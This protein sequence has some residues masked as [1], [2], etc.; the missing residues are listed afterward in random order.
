[1]EHALDCPTLWTSIEAVLTC[2]ITRQIMREP[3][4]A[5][6]GV[7][8]DRPALVRWLRHHS[9]VS[10]ITRQPLSAEELYPNRGLA[11]LIRI[12]RNHALEE[13]EEEI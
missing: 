9:S 8:Y 1:M 13:G 5:A 6:D 4:V 2:P 11:E 7:S 3:V 12:F 10:P